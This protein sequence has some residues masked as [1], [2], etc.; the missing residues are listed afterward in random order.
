MRNR[1]RVY[2]PALRLA[3]QLLASA[4]LIPAVSASAQNKRPASP[5]LFGHPN[6]NG[7]WM[8]P[9]LR[10]TANLSRA[11][12]RP[13]PLTPYGLERANEVDHAKEPGSRCLPPG[14]S[15]A[16]GGP[17]PFQIVQSDDSIAILLEFFNHFRLIYLNAEH[18]KDLEDSGPEF[19]G[20]S[21]GQWEGDVLVVDT[22][23]LDDR[24]WL[25]QGGHE[26]SDQ[27]H[28]IERFKK[29]DPDTINYTITFEDPV[30]FKEPWSVTFDLKRQNTRVLSYN[31][32]E[33]NQDL[34][35]LM[36][37]KGITGE[38]PQ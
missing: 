6:L 29:T 18:P 13:I 33:N 35:H 14:V 36:P 3:L 19:F 9:G 16:M 21:V 15:R 5:T 27:L 4:I 30:F 32:N 26:H 38:G 17:M 1:T 11:L 10:M 23:A 2:R 31:C 12:G 24:T 7:V 34:E 8:G 37:L 28:L 20:H 22:T 25:D